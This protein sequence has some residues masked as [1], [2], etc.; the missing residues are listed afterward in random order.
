[1]PDR[2]TP[3][4]LHIVR[5]EQELPSVDSAPHINRPSVS[6]SISPP[7]RPDNASTTSKR[8]LL[9]PEEASARKTKRVKGKGKATTAKS[10]EASTSTSQYYLSMIAIPYVVC[11]FT[12]CIAPSC[13]EALIASELS[14]GQRH[15]VTFNFTQLF[16]LFPFLSWWYFLR[17]VDYGLFKASSRRGYSAKKRQ[18]AAIIAAQNGMLHLPFG[19]I[20][21][22]L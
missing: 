5:Q 14:G 10:Q 1:M 20:H 2:F 16:H 12:L 8:R 22:Y 6:V 11:Y 9:E 4:P 3:S 17:I 15:V 7:P 21:V 19:P 13:F 18:E